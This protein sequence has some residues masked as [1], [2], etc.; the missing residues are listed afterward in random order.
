MHIYVFKRSYMVY[1]QLCFLWHELSISKYTS[2]HG[3]EI[4]KRSNQWSGKISKVCETRYCTRDASGFNLSMKDWNVTV[5]YVHA[6]MAY[7]FFFVVHKLQSKQYFINFLCFLMHS[8]LNLWTIWFLQ[9]IFYEISEKLDI[10][11]ITIICKKKC[12]YTNNEF[13]RDLYFR[14]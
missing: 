14:S 9:K 13:A 6:R 2:N 4:N 1:S 3:H 8:T 11:N 12:D 7:N 5:F 10:F